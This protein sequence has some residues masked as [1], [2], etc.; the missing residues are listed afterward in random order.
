M[1]KSNFSKGIASKKKKEMLL[2]AAN[3]YISIGQL[4]QYCEIM[5]ELNQVNVLFFL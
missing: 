2:K 1:A 4:E 3:I 5:V